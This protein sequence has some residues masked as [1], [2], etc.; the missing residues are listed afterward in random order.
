VTRFLNEET[1]FRNTPTLAG[2]LE[3]RLTGSDVPTTLAILQSYTENSGDAWSYTLDSI[4]RYFEKVLSD[5]AT[6]ERVVK[7]SAGAPVFELAQHPIPRFVEEMI[8]T[9][10]TDAELLGT[11]T[12]ELHLAL[13]SR[14]DV[15]AFAPEAV[16]PHYQRSI[17]QHIRTQA[18]QALQ[19]LRRRG[20]TLPDD[21]RTLAEAL[22]AREGDVQQQ[23]RK[24]L[25]GKIVAQRIRTHGD[26]HLGQ[27]LRTGNDF[28]IIDFEGEPSRPLSER[29]IK[30]SALRD[31]AGMLRSFHYAPYAVVFGQAH[32]SVIRS[33][34]APLLAAG[35]QFW[36]RWVSAAFLRAYLA[37]S[38]KGEHL[39][40][41]GAE[42]Q[43][44]LDA[45]LLEKAL[46]EIAY[47]LNNRPDW[48]RIP[49][50][51]VLDLLG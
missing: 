13:A 41:S 47:E 19:L 43:V 12:A 36:Y 49:L 20:K 15:A 3:Y 25:D 35:A 39:P 28:V 45:H 11:R 4:G 18:V 51:G 48:V 22:L 38:A 17:Y 9:Y 27:V 44:L 8:G 14:D 30:R 42:L 7:E 26:Y 24:V 10:V 21:A 1:S 37:E 46:Y 32:S 5:D 40:K 16:T 2:S 34:D 29:R 23:I 6:R 33:E 31:V 50:R